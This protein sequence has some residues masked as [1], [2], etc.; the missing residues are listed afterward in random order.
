M[1]GF[2]N[3]ISLI[4]THVSLPGKL[5]P[6]TTNLKILREHKTTEVGITSREEGSSA[7]HVAD[8]NIVKTY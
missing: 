4:R 2:S 6:A 8:A 1:E 3:V 7:F 5:K